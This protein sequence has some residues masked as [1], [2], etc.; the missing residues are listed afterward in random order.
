MNVLL[1][2][3]IVVTKLE[4]YTDYITERSLQ[5]NPE[6]VLLLYDPASYNLQQVN[7]RFSFRSFI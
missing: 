3:F 2:I 6:L 1:K 7:T 5:Y 4:P